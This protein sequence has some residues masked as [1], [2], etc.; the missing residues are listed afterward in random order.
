MQTPVTDS[1]LAHG[2]RK[3]TAAR[4]AR[5]LQPRLMEAL[6]ADARIAC[7]YRQE[8]HEFRSRPDGVLQV[9]RLML[10]TD[11]FAALAAYRLKARLESLGIPV[12]PWIAHQ[13]AV[14]S[15]G[16]SIGDGVVLHPGVV[17]PHGHVV[18]HGLVEIEPFVTLLP[19]V[20]VGP[21][22]GGSAG[23]TIRGG[24][25]IGTGAK[26]MGEIEIGAN[27]RVGVNAV[28]LD[29]VPANTTVVGMPAEPI[30][31]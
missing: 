13:I 9:L 19:W 28:V 24:A 22:G 27:S 20:T 14:T 17:I 4:E 5:A 1:K 16:I 29:D 15:A 7:A 10:K 12:L 18:V 2:P 6:I 31:E 23:P 30:A 26:V 11:A 21:I 25:V 3:E 8:R